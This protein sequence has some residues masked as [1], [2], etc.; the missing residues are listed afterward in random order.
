[1]N[2]QQRP[3]IV[4]LTPKAA[5]LKPDELSPTKVSVPLLV[6]EAMPIVDSCCPKIQGLGE[7]LFSTWP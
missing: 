6:G 2:R 3:T 4:M 7:L 1:M 5:Q